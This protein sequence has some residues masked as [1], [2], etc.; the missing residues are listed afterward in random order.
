MARRDKVAEAIRQEVSLIV[1]D[2]LKD[3]RLGF[4]TIMRVEVTDDLRY[5]K[6]FFSVLGKDEDYKK[7]QEGLDSAR[8][9]IRKLVSDRLSL[10]FSPEIAFYE[11]RSSEY[12]V[13]IEE[14]L[15]E[16]KQLE[17][18]KKETKKV[19]RVKRKAKGG[20]V[21]PKKVRRGNKKK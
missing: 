8:G 2:V 4:V 13:R 5:A 14:V 7:T 9:F 15:N 20:K 16:L 21:E 17:E 3:P 1:H 19:K 18:A 6:V 12:S 10:K 11:D